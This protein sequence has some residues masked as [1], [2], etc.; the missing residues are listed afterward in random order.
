MEWNSNT[1][2]TPQSNNFFYSPSFGLMQDSFE[3]ENQAN[4]PQFPLS[5]N[6]Q[7]INQRINNIRDELRNATREIDDIQRLLQPNYEEDQFADSSIGELSS[8]F[9]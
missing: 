4:N 3:Q 8:I 7:R 2:T 1:S 5:T 9:Q 6:A